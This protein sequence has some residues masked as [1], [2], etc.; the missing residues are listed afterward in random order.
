MWSIQN[1]DRIFKNTFWH[2]KNVTPTWHLCKSGV[3]SKD[4]IYQPIKSDGFHA[5]LH[6][7]F[8]TLVVIVIGPETL[9]FFTSFCLGPTSFQPSIFLRI[10]R[11]TTKRLVRFLSMSRRSAT[12][13]PNWGSQLIQYS[14][15]E[16]SLYGLQSAWSAFCTDRKSCGP[17]CVLAGLKKPF[18]L[19]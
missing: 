6:V 9:T 5:D 8:V 1:A 10:T 19:I 7:R 2:G 18:T 3:E 11:V 13:V 16:I 14:K 4:Q 17:L 12:W 15:K